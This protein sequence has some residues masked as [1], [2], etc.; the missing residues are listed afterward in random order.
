MCILISTVEEEEWDEELQHDMLQKSLSSL[1]PNWSIASSDDDQRLCVRIEF[2]R[3]QVFGYHP[4]KT[5]KAG[6]PIS[7]GPHLSIIGGFIK[8][9]T[10]D[11][12]SS[13]CGLTCHHSTVDG[14]KPADQYHG[15]IFIGGHP[16]LERTTC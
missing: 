1:D 5:M 4:T 13:V 15:E 12:Q 9:I 16:N 10:Q 14:M 11:D 6:Y 2:I 7:A 8:M 3:V